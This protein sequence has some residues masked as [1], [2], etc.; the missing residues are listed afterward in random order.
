MFQY[1]CF[2]LVYTITIL[3]FSFVYINKRHDKIN[4]SFLLFLGNI[5]VWMIIDAGSVYLDN[6]LVDRLIKVIY[7][8]AMMNIAVFF[9]NFVYQLLQKK[10][11]R[12]FY[13]VVLINSATILIRF[14][15]PIDF[16]QPNFWQ[17]S[18]PV[19]APMMA[20]V[21]CLPMAVAIYLIVQAYRSS[22]HQTLKTQL[23]YL[24]IGIVSA[25]L[26]S[27]ISENLIP[28]MVQFS[29]AF[30][31]MYLAYFVLNLFLYFAIIRHKF[32][33][34]PTEYIYQKMFLNS[35]EGMLIIDQDATIISSNTVA[36]EILGDFSMD[37]R[38]QITQYLPDYSFAAKYNRDEIQI[39]VGDEIRCLLVVQSPIDTRDRSS[40]KL[41]Q[42]SDITVSKRLM[43][44]ENEAL[45]DRAY[46]DQLTGL[47]NRHYIY[48][49]FIND[50]ENVLKKVTVLFMDIDHFKFIND[51][52]GHRVGDQVIQAIG[53][54]IKAALRHNE[55]AIR[56][57]GDEF[58]II[59]E[60]T[61][62]VD[63]R[64]IAERVQNKVRLIE[65][66]EYGDK[67]RITLSI[68]L[69]EGIGDVNTIINQADKAMYDSKKQGKNRISFYRQYEQNQKLESTC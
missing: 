6:N 48:D 12:L 15:L 40:A 27:L 65:I 8:V 13:G 53:K 45:K 41:L 33:N 38:T 26:V 39:R 14:A 17:L 34:I 44:K 52:L 68:G 21:F 62:T 59:L 18:D 35:G 36:R 28:R 24:L 31:L 1:V 4:Q 51:A 61:L 50:K 2:I 43:V 56:Y 5:M 29:G 63:A 42:L 19:A 49:R 22:T 25:T 66:P 7:F 69:S 60:D 37:D 11:D 46:I 64:R 47:Y 10:I 23:N 57:G 32:L 58:I 30:S 54:S 20:A 9:M 67:I 16:V 3:I 55:T